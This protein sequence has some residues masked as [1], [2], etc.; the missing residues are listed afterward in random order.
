MCTCFPSL[1]A[2]KLSVYEARVA[3]LVSDTQELPESLAN[4]GKVP[5]SRHAIAR[6]IGTCSTIRL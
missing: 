3:A 2:A 6:L 4:T 1:Q 5:L